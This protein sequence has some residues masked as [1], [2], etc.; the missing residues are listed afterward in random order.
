M[1]GIKREIPRDV[2]NRALNNHGYIVS[3]DEDRVFTRSE[4][5][6]YG[7]YRQ[8]VFEEDGKC[9]VSFER[10]DSCD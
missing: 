4:V 7:V 9:Y 5:L 8:C 2:Y 1:T 10:G 6:G 3:N